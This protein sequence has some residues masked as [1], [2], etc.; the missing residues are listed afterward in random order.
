M[1]DAF[2]HLHKR[3]RLHK[4]LEPYPHPDR[5]KNFFDKLIYVVSIMV[6]AVTAIQAWKI[7]EEKNADGVSVIAFV[8]YIIGNIV[9]VIYGMLHKDA[10]IV[11]MYV[12]LFFL[13]AIIVVGT[14]IF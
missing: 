8:G 12:L 11:L 2:H 5:V 4:K 10:P 7:W 14:L 3:K 1:I 6:P 13:N 9:W